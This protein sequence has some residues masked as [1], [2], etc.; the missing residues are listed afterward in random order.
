MIRTI[1]LAGGS[2]TRLWPLSRQ[3]Y[4]KQF[5]PLFDKQS[6]FQQT[7]LRNELSEN[8][9]VTND[10]L[11]FLVRDQ[12]A[13]LGLKLPTLILEPVG[14]NTAPAITLA[15]L[16]GNPEDI[17][18]VT[19]SD[20]FIKN[21][22]AYRGYLKHAKTLAQEGHLVTLGTTPTYAA[23]GYGYIEA[24]GQNVRFFKEKPN[25]DLADQYLK[26]GNYFWNSGLFIFKA[27][28]YLEELA[29]F[30][31]EI[32]EMSQRALG[33]ASYEPLFQATRI[34]LKDMEAIPA[35]SIDYAVMEKSKRIK[36]IPTDMGWSD[37]GSFDELYE[38]LPQDSSQNAVIGEHIGL[39]ST[40]N[41]IIAPSDKTVATIGLSG[42]IVV[43]TED[44]LLV[45]KQGCS[46]D[47]KLIVEKLRKAKSSKTDSHLTVHRPWG[48]YTILEE[49]RNHY[50]LKRLV[51]KPK[52]KLS[53][54]KH[55][56]RNEHW[57]VVS[58]TARIQNGEDIRILMA[59]E[60]TYIPMGQ[61]HRLEN[62]ADT[63]LVIIEVQVGAFL[64][65]DDIVR[66]EDD[67]LRR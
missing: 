44:A 36:V 64:S 28:T 59:N 50:I 67:F 11:F 42:M 32:L 57:V 18:V 56:H 23:T 39:E 21:T 62:P 31:P 47:V 16:Q 30:A 29:Q 33:R 19:P 5:L 46:Q 66:V 54:Q 6:L 2:G 51:V 14:R 7:L 45:A 1:I 48:T 24:E 12:T 20:H 13:E 55:A 22:K 41:L 34:A 58:G 65:E 3:N 43:A 8:V 27:R 17:V 60:S 26:K 15:C 49:E 35:N 9:V 63:D 53:L 4:P 38:A 52:H 61:L 10:A 40:H 37:L 25:K